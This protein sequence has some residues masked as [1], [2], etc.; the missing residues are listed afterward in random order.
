MKKGRLER[1][2]PAPLLR[3][4]DALGNQI[5]LASFRPRPVLVEFHR[6]TW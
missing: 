4:T 5:D 6:G 2:D 3:G 1:G